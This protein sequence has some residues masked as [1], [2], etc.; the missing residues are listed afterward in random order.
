MGAGR[1]KWWW[2]GMCWVWALLCWS[3]HVPSAPAHFTH[4]A[5]V[6]CACDASGALR[7]AEARARE[8]H[9]GLWDRQQAATSTCH[10]QGPPPPCHM[11]ASG[12][13]PPSKTH[14]RHDVGQSAPIHQQRQAKRPR[15]QH[16]RARCA[17]DVRVIAQARPH[18][19][20]RGA[21]EPGQDALRRAVRLRQRL[22][23]ALA[24]L[25]ALLV[26]GLVA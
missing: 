18:D 9:S 4:V 19:H 20:G 13:A 10:C 22:P 11:D 15:L 24:L 5:G 21:L 8:G 25:P 12:A 26:L 7:R 14:P 6:V 3:K 17:A 1:S 16:E 23:C 2:C